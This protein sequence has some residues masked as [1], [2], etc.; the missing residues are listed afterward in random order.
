MPLAA[1][2]AFASL[3]RRAIRETG[4]QHWKHE[5][6]LPFLILHPWHTVAL[7]HRWG[8]AA[9]LEG[10]GAR[11][12]EFGGQI[13]GCSRCSA[14]RDLAREVE[15]LEKT[16]QFEPQH[17]FSGMG[18]CCS[19]NGCVGSGTRRK[20]H[21]QPMQLGANVG[22]EVSK[23]PISLADDSSVRAGGPIFA[24]CCVCQIFLLLNLEAA[25]NQQPN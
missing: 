10:N 16:S 11:R 12:S 22:I 2:A 17:P 5:A 25:A 20:H 24:W 19:L 8:T 15:H 14:S 4:Q 18:L 21:L 23:L 6:A 9:G 3:I 1:P 7:N 13:S